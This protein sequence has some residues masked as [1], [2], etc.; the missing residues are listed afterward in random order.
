VL[1]LDASVYHSSSDAADASTNAWIG[2]TLKPS[3]RVSL[4]LGPQFDHQIVNAQYVD[5]VVIGT[6]PQYVFATLRAD[7]V[8]LTARLNAI[9]TARLSLQLYA[10]SLAATGRYTGFKALAA[11]ATY[12]FV[13][14]EADLVA[15]PDFEPALLNLHTVARW[16]W[17]RGSALYLVWTQHRLGSLGAAAAA[18]SQLV[19]A[20]DSPSANA[21]M[22]KFTYWIGR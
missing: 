1:S 19:R 16:E 17:Q 13:P 5:T 2:V 8:A 14:L 12:S 10:Q 11:P 21:A 3:P 22:A 15:D 7:D 4:S 9:A 18:P 20:F 6:Q